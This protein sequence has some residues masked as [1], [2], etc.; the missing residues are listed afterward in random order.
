[1]NLSKIEVENSPHFMKGALTA[2]VAWVLFMKLPSS[3]C[4]GLLA[5]SFALFTVWKL[6]SARWVDAGYTAALVVALR[7][8]FVLFN[9][10]GPLAFAFIATMSLAVLVEFWQKARGLESDGFDWKD[11][12]FDFL[13]WLYLAAVVFVM[14][15]PFFWQ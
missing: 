13:G 10:N 7:S 6:K 2:L 11:L 4:W 8:I 9:Q 1:M 15:T 12:L 3:L 5:A 14:E